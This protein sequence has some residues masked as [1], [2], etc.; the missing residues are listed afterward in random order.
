M[1]H[2]RFMCATIFVII[3]NRKSFEKC[4]MILVIMGYYALF[5][6]NLY[7]Q[8]SLKSGG[9]NNGIGFGETR[10]ELISLCSTKCTQIMH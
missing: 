5:S 6:T 10:T 3:E 8:S 9:Q 7:A 2:V 1:K 4:K